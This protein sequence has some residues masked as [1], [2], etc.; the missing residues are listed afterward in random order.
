MGSRFDLQLFVEKTWAAAGTC[1]S[2]ST[3][4]VHVDGAAAAAGASAGCQV[5]RPVSNYQLIE[6]QALVDF[7]GLGSATP[8]EPL[9]VVCAVPRDWDALPLQSTPIFTHQQWKAP[10]AATGM[11]IAL[12]ICRFP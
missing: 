5:A 12:S 11:G 2:N 7:S 6:H 3:F 4:V 1:F 10:S 9:R 8:Q